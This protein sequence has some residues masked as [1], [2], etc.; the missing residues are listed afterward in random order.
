MRSLIITFVSILA[1]S[2][3]EAQN[4]NKYL[5]EARTSYSAQ[6]L[7]N[8][9]FAMQQMLEE[10][11]IMAGKDALKL[12]PA[13]LETLKANTGN[14]N[15]TGNTGFTGIMIHRDYGAAEK[16][17]EIEIIGNSPLIASVNAFLSLPFGNNNGN[18][19]TIK[20]DG[21][22]ALLQK[23][24]DNDKTSYEIQ[25]PLNSSL[26]TLKASGVTEDGIQK[27]AGLIPVSKLAALLQ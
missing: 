22:K 16:T 9:R 1:F 18:Q 26:L 2:Q 24:S 14:D 20:V 7:D 13:S 25:I 4:F 6:K 5:S 10:L 15:V 8:A 3:A 12:L 23:N 11:D 17:A 27:L 19:R 21:Y